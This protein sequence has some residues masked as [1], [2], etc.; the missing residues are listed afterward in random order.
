[1][2]LWIQRLDGTEGRFVEPE[3]LEIP[4]V[5]MHPRF[6]PDGKW[7]VF[8]SDR[9][10]LND[11]PALTWFPQ[12]YGDLWAVPADGAAAVR[13]LHNKWEDGPSDWGFVRLPGS[14]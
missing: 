11:E 5:S 6:S 4:D 12:P 1:M 14:R 13:L 9:G 10:G 2:K 7:I 8:T 3:R